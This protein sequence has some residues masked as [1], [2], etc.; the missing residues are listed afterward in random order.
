M[1]V[2]GVEGGCAALLPAPARGVSPSGNKY[3]R[4]VLD[5]LAISS[6]DAIIDVG[7]GKGSAMCIMLEFPFWRV[8][9]IELSQR[10]V[11]IA[12]R[13]FRRLNVNSTRCEVISGDAAEFAEYDQYSHVYFYNPFT[14]EIMS[15]V[16]D[17]LLRSIERNPREVVVIYNTPCCHAEVV[18]H[19]VF[20][21]FADYPGTDHHRIHVYSNRRRGEAA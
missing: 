20:R 11:D 6:N 9:G 12:R 15:K 21:Q 18:R 17:H 16:V 1:C 5:N 13:N 19:D 8:A 2:V 10:I 14:T 7:C 3:L 4:T